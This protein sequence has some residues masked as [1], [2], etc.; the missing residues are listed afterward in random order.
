MNNFR[1]ESALLHRRIVV[2]SNEVD[3]TGI[4]ARIWSSKTS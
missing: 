3:L 2:Q 4:V 1:I